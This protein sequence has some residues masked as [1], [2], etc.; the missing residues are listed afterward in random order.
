MDDGTANHERAPEDH[1]FSHAGPI[2]YLLT[3]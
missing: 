3:A 2:G 1:R